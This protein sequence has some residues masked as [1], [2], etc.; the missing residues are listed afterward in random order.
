MKKI[1]IF[2]VMLSNILI[3]TNIIKGV[4]AN[5]DDNITEQTKFFF[6]TQLFIKFWCK[7]MCQ[8]NSLLQLFC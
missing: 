7:Y 6:I 8:N 4:K 2:I 3:T 1:I 5:S